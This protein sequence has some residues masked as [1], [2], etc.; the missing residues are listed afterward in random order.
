MASQNNEISK[1]TNIIKDLQT[2]IISLT[3]TIAS[4][5]S[6][7]IAHTPASA[8]EANTDTQVKPNVDDRSLNVV[9]YGITESPPKPLDLIDLVMI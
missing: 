9:V 4:L 5:Q 1:L 6:F 2:V 7:V 3:E 8:Q